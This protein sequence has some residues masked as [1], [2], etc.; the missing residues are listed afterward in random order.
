LN[1]Y[2]IWIIISIWII[3]N[4]WIIRINSY[5]EI[6]GVLHGDV[7][8]TPIISFRIPEHFFLFLI[9]IVF[10]FL[11]ENLLFEKTI[12]PWNKGRVTRLESSDFRFEGAPFKLSGLFHFQVVLDFLFF[13]FFLPSNG[14]IQVL[15]I[16][17]CR[18]II[19]RIILPQLRWLLKWMWVSIKDFLRAAFAAFNLVGGFFSFFSQLYRFF[20]D[21]G[22]KWEYLFLIL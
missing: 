2:F 13:Q 9:E 19:I 20:I 16:V 18:D 22:F 15:R 1:N 12:E 5:R 21:F 11:G 3:I 4:I 14:L 10:L 8:L 6:E 17:V 7:L